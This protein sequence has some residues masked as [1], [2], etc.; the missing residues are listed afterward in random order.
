MCELFN[1][2]FRGTTFVIHLHF[3]VINL[4]YE[5]RRCNTSQYASAHSTRQNTI[6]LVLFLCVDLQ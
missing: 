4:Q 3:S 1:Y 5:I 6:G 2:Y